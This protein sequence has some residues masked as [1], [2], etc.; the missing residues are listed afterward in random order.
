MTSR[1]PG[2]LSAQVKEA[3]KLQGEK[4]KKSY[5]MSQAMSMPV[6]DPGQRLPE[7]QDYVQ[8]YENVRERYKGRKSLVL[9]AV[10]ALTVSVV[11]LNER[12]ACCSMHA[13]VNV[14]TALIGSILVLYK[15]L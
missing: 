6:L 8:A 7:E 10:V 1:Q 2:V 14:V 11:S 13:S 3:W 4:F 12:W 5:S 15:C 9:S